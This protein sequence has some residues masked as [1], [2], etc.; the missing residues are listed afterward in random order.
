MRRQ[1]LD[2]GGALKMLVS[3]EYSRDGVVEAACL[4]VN[5]LGF[6]RPDLKQHQ[7]L[8]QGDAKVKPGLPRARWRDRPGE[9]P[10]RGELQHQS[11]WDQFLKIL[12]YY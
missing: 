11:R 9:V 10:V 8:N 2:P 5:I 12:A 4:K 1:R 6:S 3:L 7:V